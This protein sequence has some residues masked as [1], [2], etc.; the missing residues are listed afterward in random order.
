MPDHVLCAP[1]ILYIIHSIPQSRARARFQ[2]S[3]YEDAREALQTALQIEELA[4]PAKEI[5][6]SP[7]P[8]MRATA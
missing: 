1:G 4:E 2:R 8:A 5:F 3:E 7:R 6:A